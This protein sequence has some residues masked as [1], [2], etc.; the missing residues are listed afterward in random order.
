MR[1]SPTSAITMRKAITMSMAITMSTR[2]TSMTTTMSMMRTGIITS[3][4][5]C[6]KSRPSFAMP[7]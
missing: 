7:T 1:T 3:I 5:A 4:A 6:Q 2:P